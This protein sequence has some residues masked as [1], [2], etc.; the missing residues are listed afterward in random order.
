MQW[1][2]RFKIVYFGSLPLVFPLSFSSLSLILIKIN[3]D[4]DGAC[5][6][7]QLLILEKYMV[8]LA[9]KLN[10]SSAK[11]HPADC[12]QLIGGIGYGG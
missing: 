12:F 4:A 10:V 1:Y 5:A 2:Y 9:R 7:A 3:A 8:V 11:L 6:I